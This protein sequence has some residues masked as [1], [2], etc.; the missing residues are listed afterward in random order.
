MNLKIKFELNKELDKQMAFNFGTRS[1]SKGGI[2]FTESVFQPH[3]DLR[4]I[5]G[6]ENEEQKQIISDYIDDFYKTHEEEL[7]ALVADMNDNWHK[8]EENFNEQVKTIFKNPEIPEGKYI[9]YLSVINCNPRFLHD[10]TFQV[11]YKHRAG[12]NYVTAHETLHFFFYDY[13]A[14]K[15]P[16]LFANLNPNSGVYWDMAELFDVVVMSHPDFISEEYAKNTRPYPSHAKYCDTLKEIW[17][18]DLDIDN[19]IVKSYKYLSS[20]A[21]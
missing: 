20:Q 14:K 6:K 9:G 16:E 5:V 21:S 3:P 4:Q 12:S 1:A 18:K 19:W 11:F 8:D 10:K 7:R 15:H 17:N 2:D 13:T